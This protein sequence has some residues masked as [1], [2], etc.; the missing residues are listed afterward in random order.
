MNELLESIKK[1]ST[2]EL[3]HGKPISSVKVM[4]KNHYN[5]YTGLTTFADNSKAKIVTLNNQRVWYY[6]QS[7]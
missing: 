6:H 5:P 7:Y 1:L 4:G 3:L 2:A